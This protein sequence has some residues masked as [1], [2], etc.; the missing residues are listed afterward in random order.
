MA[1]A[2][3]VYAGA[4]GGSLTIKEPA[5]SVDGNGRFYRKQLESKAEKLLI[6]LANV[7][8]ADC[9]YVKLHPSAS[10]EFE[11]RYDAMK[12]WNKE[13]NVYLID[14]E[15]NE[16]GIYAVDEISEGKIIPI[17]MQVSE[18]GK[19][20]ITLN[21]SENFS[22]GTDL[23]L[24]DALERH[25]MP[26]GINFSYSFFIS[27]HSKPKNERFYLTRRREA[28]MP[29]ANPLAQVYPNPVKDVLQIHL[30]KSS[31]STL[32][33]LN[34]LGN[35]CW[36]GNGSALFNIDMNHFAPGLYLLR[37]ETRGEIEIV[38]VVKY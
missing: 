15:K 29:D 20:T 1:Q 22:D 23:Y 27:D 14:D 17:G 2:F 34:S 12:L 6:T 26:V 18:P 32:S 35:V 16:L 10:S 24:I 38:K 8:S 3:W 19:Y 33:L 5:K 28:P 9:A 4:G 37:V 36:T 31:M 13:V 30:P 11:L 25:T 7:N 21:R